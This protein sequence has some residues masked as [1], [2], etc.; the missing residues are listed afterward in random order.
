MT[1]VAFNTLARLQTTLTK[2]AASGVTS[3]DRHD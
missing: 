1:R 3:S 2:A